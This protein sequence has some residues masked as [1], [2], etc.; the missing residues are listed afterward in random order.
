MAE[1]SIIIIGAGIAGLSTGCYGQMSG[2]NTQIFELHDK[3]GGL[4]T[5]WKRKGYTFDGCIHWLVGSG[6]GTSFNRVWS[7]LGAL[8]G[9]SIVD[10]EEFLRIEGTDGKALIIYTNIDQL[11]QH[12]NEL[13][14][15]DAEVIKEFAD[16]VRFFSR[17]EM[18][19]GKPRELYSLLDGLKSAF[20]MRKFMRPFMKWKKLS[21]REFASRFSDPF[22]REAFPLILDLDDFPMAAVLF[23]LAVMHNHDAGYPIGGSL[24]FSQAIKQRYLDLG[25]EIHYKSRVEKI[26]VE[27]D[28]AVG[29]KLTD[30]TEHRA[31]VVVSA[32]DGHATI[33][34]MLEGKYVNDKIRGY[35][36][37]LP[38]FQP[39]IQVSLGVARD[40]SDEPQTIVYA[41][42]EPV[43]IAGK[44]R[45]HLEIKHYCFDPTLT[46][47]G[48]SAVT[49]LISSNYDYWKP[50]L[51][52]RG[53]YENEKQQIA[54]VVINQLDKRFPGIKEQVEIVDVATP[55][56]FERYT[57]NWQGSFEGWLIT[58][59]SFG[60]SMS[61]TLPGLKSFY[62]VG[63]WVE[64]GGG[65]PTSAL[66]GRNVMQIICHQDKK[67]FVAQTP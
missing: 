23:T 27:N 9:R 56:T 66:S 60:M 51:E 32:A 40:L 20:G 61:K 36:D 58:T 47:Q 41:L 53:R 46:P 13:S 11:E 35:Y 54:D 57:G 65:L 28:H 38:I 39:Y 33:F 50:L 17:S 48:K 37:K 52:D 55:T 8:Q 31:D 7:E 43:S 44:E 26:L 25:G 1:K 14:P 21:V 67:Q 49:V 3:P 12:M 2:Y 16:A 59:K 19:L 64:P 62:M 42:E 24:P 29:I 34:D 18:P 30:G 45:R 6:S 22:L 4:C 63:Q 15:A 10:H 5:S